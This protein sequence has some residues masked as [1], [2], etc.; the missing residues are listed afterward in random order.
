MTDP[1]IRLARR[2]PLVRQDQPLFNALKDEFRQRRFV[3][4]PQFLD[5]DFLAWIQDQIAH[6]SMKLR[7]HGN[8]IATEL[9]LPECTCLGLLTFYVNDPAV[10]A[11]VADL[12]AEPRLTRF[13][14]RVYH[15]LPGVH[16]DNW[17]DDIHPARK[18][19]MSINLSDAVYEGSV[20]QMR[21]AE[22]KRPLGEIANTGF[23]DAIFFDIAEDLEHRTSPLTGTA[24]KTAYAGWFG[25]TFDYNATL[26]NDP[27]LEQP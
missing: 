2:G 18:V 23:G 1:L 3:K 19:G 24:S 20:F 12:A 10:L 25:A 14:G 5:A 16:H 13:I 8:D 6:E 17:H 26:K 21:E 4:I 7:V 15:R 27:A 11:F 9:S 22:T